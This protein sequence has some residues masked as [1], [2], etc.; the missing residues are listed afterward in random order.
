MPFAERR[1]R[2][3]ST[4]RA[5]L[6]DAARRLKAARVSFGHGTTN[7]YDEAAWL[8][9][10]ALGLPVD[11]LQLHL[12]RALAADETRQITALIDARIRSRK[13]AAYLL[14]EAWLGEHRF[15]VDE[16]VIVPRSYIA[17]L[18]QDDL[19][20][21]VA[22]PKQV[23][24][25]LDLCTGSGCLAILLALTFPHSRVDASDISQDALQVAKRNVTDYHLSRRVS[26]VR[27]NL[28][29]KLRNRRYDVIV[30]NPPYVREAVMRRLPA[31]YRKE[32]VLALAG[33]HDGL[34]LVKRVVA[35]AALHLNPGGL[36]VVEVGHNRKRVEAAF[37]R[38]PLIW[39]ETSGGDDCV[40]LIT[41]ETL[42][43][44]D[45]AHSSRA[46]RAAA[47]PRSQAT[48]S[49]A[50]ASGA[51]AVQRRRSA[52]ASGGSR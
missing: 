21:W 40:F 7:A 28:Y 44:A 13:P 25:T 43:A 26:L 9:A 11:A 27:S 45:R 24:T 47:S 32:P 10:H 2:A 38:L 29:S 17:E 41:R 23:R 35:E 30:S 42:L 15:Y 6:R 19:R 34:D 22:R 14:H 33:G 1:P 8:S 18:L 51:A 48:N 36:L 50:R 39:A 4:L 52:R 16:R 49:P 37:P 46:S 31:E 12:D 5:F 3:R 20:P